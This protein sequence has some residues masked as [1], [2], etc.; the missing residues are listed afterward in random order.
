MRYSPTILFMLLT[1][2]LTAQTNASGSSAAVLTV[3][4]TSESCPVNF[5]ASRK[6]VGSV[7]AAKGAAAPHQGQGLQFNFLSAGESKVIKAD[8]TVHGIS[9]Q[10]RVIPASSAA[11]RDSTETFTL[12]SE[13][14]Q[15]LFYSS[16][17]LNKLNG[18]SWA[19]LTNI[20][21]AD[22]TVWHAS[23]TFR[24]SAVPSRTLLI[25][26]LR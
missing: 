10:T 2:G 17:W 21:F 25:A 12:R 5:F 13:N 9:S 15:V 18:A 8:I 23:S 16:V 1:F 3:P 11:E 14:G 20:E 26:G 22:G 19:E 6:A 7:M 24:C 4:P